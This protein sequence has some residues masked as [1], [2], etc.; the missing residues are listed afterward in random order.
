MEQYPSGAGGC[1][2]P[3]GRMRSR[4]FA[5][6]GEAE[7]AARRHAEFFRDFLVP[8]APTSRLRPSIENMD[9]CVQ[10]LDNV[11]AALDW[12]FSPAGD[13]AIGVVLTAAYTP[14]WIHF[15]LMIECSERAERALDCLG[16]DLNLAAPLRMQLYIG[17][18]LSLIFTM[19]PVERAKMILAK[20]LEVAESLD[21][22]D[23]QLW[24]LWALWGLSLNISECRAAQSTAERF[25][26]V[27]V[28]TGYP[29]DVLVADRLIG[30]TLQYGGKLRETRHRFERVLEL[31]IS[32]ENKRHRILFHSDQ[33][34]LTRAMLARVLW[35]QGFVNQAKDNARAC[36]EEAQATGYELSLCWVIYYAVYP[37]ALMTNDLVAAERAMATLIRLATGHNVA[38]WKIVA[39]CLEAKLLIKRGE[40]GNGSALMRT[41]LETCDKSGWTI[42]YPEFLGVLAEGL[43]GLGEL[44]EAL[45]T[46]D[47]ALAKAD[48][49]GE[50]W[51]VAEILRVKGELLLQQAGNRSISAAEVCFLDAR[52]IARQQ[53][54][55]FWELRVALSL[56]RLRV[57][58]NRQDDA[59]QLL[60]PAYDRF[61]EGFETADLHSAK[62]MLES[63]SSDR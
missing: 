48:R 30:T 13:P 36:V 32:P 37:I 63:L 3:S 61:V 47:Q 43:A 50:R 62:A 53:G 28:R 42:C 11:R 14:V 23:A 16:P 49:G 19:G 24:N 35:L 46:V 20:A 45:A 25:S 44:T 26:R 51:Y 58:Q 57:R 21:D 6:S 33:R 10:E 39:R 41:A 9:R 27:A 59:R 12:A 29:A 54:A 56:A 22:L 1:S 52:E 40:F 38:F 15:E 34:V 4:N 60:K 8:T 31:Y 2:K 18:G 55:L 7:E 17:L 5:E